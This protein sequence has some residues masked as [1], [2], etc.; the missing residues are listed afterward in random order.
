MKVYLTVH[1]TAVT[2]LEV[3][4]AVAGPLVTHPLG[5]GQLSVVHRR[6]EADAVVT[7]T[8]TPVVNTLTGWP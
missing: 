5:W 8:P 4:G 1:P 6:T 7:L 2:P 3:F